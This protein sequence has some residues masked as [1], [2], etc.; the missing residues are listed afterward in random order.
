[1]LTCVCTVF[2][3][4]LTNLDIVNG[5]CYNSSVPQNVTFGYQGLPFGINTGSGNSSKKGAAPGRR[6]GGWW[7]V[8]GV[9][10]LSLVLGWAL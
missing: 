9:V 6:H 4:D 8:G 7:N 1:M 2:Q 5:Q 10:V 3:D